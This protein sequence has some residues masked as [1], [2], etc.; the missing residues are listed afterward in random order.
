[1][2]ITDTEEIK[3]VEFGDAESSEIS[4]RDNEI[5]I[6]RQE[7]YL[8]YSSRQ[9]ITCDGEAICGKESSPLEAIRELG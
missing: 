4:I 3:F 8:C 9:T 7:D 6:E 1:M 2:D 5:E